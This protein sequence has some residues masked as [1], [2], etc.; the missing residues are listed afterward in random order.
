M[1]EVSIEKAN[2]FVLHKQ[3]LTEDSKTD[4]IV[5]IVNDISGLHATGSTTP[6]LSLFARTKNFTKNVLE[7]EINIRRRLGKIRCMRKTLHILTKE[8]IPV[9]YAATK[10]MFILVSERYMHYLG[11][12]SEE[13]K[14]ISKQILDI[15]NNR[16]MTTTEIKNA[17][18]TKVNTSPIVNLMCD[19]GLLIRGVSRKGWKSNLHTYF[20]FNRYFPD[21]DLHKLKEKEAVKLLVKQYLSSFGPV[22]E[23][24]I[25][26]WTGLGKTMIKQLL[27]ELEKQTLIINISNLKG[28]FILLKTDKRNLKYFNLSRK[29]IVNFLPVQDP[30]IMGYKERERYIDPG[31]YDNVFDRSGNAAA[32]ILLDGRVIGVWDFT[33]KA[34]STV[35][36]YLF[37]KVGKALLK[38]I[39]SEASRIGKFIA[40][41]EVHIKECKHMISLR[42]RTLG[43]FM[44]PLKGC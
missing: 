20:S 18:K 10:K 34:E 7:E 17:L 12:S 26:W 28:N 2:Q 19:Q 41:K 3:H 39:Y 37:K 9:A 32:T 35:K 43:G 21:L 30:Y 27:K 31:D 16:A 29:G 4:D 25:S 44:S 1:S 36:I 5:K 13:Y 23:N 6:Y 14:E 42:E 33:E 15:L 22:T 38:R 40:D 24:D 8:M 11:V